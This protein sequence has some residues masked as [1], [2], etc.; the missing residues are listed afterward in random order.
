MDDQISL[1]PLIRNLTQQ[2]YKES[3]ESSVVGVPDD[4]KSSTMNSDN[5]QIIGQETEETEQKC[6][7]I[8]HPDLDH[9]ELRQFAKR[10]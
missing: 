6:F 3:T 4:D 1:L 2:L 9:P 8:A 7:D 5:P 10:K